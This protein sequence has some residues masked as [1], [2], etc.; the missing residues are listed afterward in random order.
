M[1]TV[2]D[3]AEVM[4]IYRGKL[5]PQGAKKITRQGIPVLSQAEGPG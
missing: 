1:L 5:M 4:I 3:S 2:N